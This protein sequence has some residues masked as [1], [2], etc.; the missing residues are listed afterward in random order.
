MP[1][2][3]SSPAD[4]SQPPGILRNSTRRE[5][6]AA[7][8]GSESDGSN[9]RAR[10]DAAVAIP[11]SQTTKSPL[12]VAEE[13]I[14]SHVE[15]LR[16]GLASLLL[17]RGKEYITLRHKLF[18][19]KKNRSRIEKDEDYVPGSA[20]V[21]FKLGSMKEVEEL[22][23]FQELQTRATEITL[24][25]QQEYKALIIDLMKL[26]EQ[27]LRE[28]INKK[29]CN[30]LAEA[31]SLFLV[32]HGNDSQHTHAVVTSM[33]SVDPTVLKYTDLNPTTFTAL[34]NSC[35]DCGDYDV[36]DADESAEHH[37]AIIRALNSVF[38]ESWKRYLEQRK[39]N[40]LCLSIQK[41]AK[42]SRLAKA[43][44]DAVMTVDA[45][46]PAD[47]EQL[48]ELIQKQA[49]IIAKKLIDKALAKDKSKSDKPK[50][51]TPKNSKRGPK[52]TGANQKN[53]KGNSKSRDDDS[54]SDSSTG[55]RR[56]KKKPAK[57][58]SK[59]RPSRRRGQQADAAD[60]DSTAD[61]RKKRDGRSKSKSR[62]KTSGKG[63]RQNQS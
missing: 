39:E 59:S 29:L 4:T 60:S 6:P 30:S 23:G 31:T 54:Q 19:K 26:E 53:Q 12:K 48:Q 41:K 46:L 50:G 21:K 62:K 1:T 5:P 33:V 43:T 27:H 17:D 45:E 56:N 16:Q 51:S 2:L 52:K 11:G 57:K 13:F 35:V 7:E 25:R 18:L 8:S 36:D 10:I 55:S 14:V 9:K 49:E 63:N 28:L 47:R 38:N 3:I 42:E 61:K 24:Q 15:S 58:K 34:Y 20:R 37:P 40:D 44:E 22:P 32:A